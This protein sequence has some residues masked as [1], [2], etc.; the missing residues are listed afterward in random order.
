[1]K[2]AMDEPTLDRGGLHDAGV[3]NVGLL[4][5]LVL[6]VPVVGLEASSMTDRITWVIQTGRWNILYLALISTVIAYV[7]FADGVQWIGAERAAYVSLV[8]PFVC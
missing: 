6:L 1:M 5:G 2:R 7:W 8:P 3:D 4:V